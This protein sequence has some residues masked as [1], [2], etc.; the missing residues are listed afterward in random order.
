MKK[1]STKAL[2]RDHAVAIVLVVLK[3]GARH[4]YEIAREVERRTGSTIY[5]NDGTLYPVLHALEDDGFIESAW[6][7]SSERPRRTYAIKAAGL[8]ELDKKIAEWKRFSSAVNE[9][10]SGET[11]FALNL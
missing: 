11:A 7:T 4:G 3:D 2:S 5:F 10:L 8:A 1:K 6:D 9:L